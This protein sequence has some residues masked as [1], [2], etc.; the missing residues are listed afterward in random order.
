MLDGDSLQPGDVILSSQKANFSFLIRTFTWSGYSHAAIVLENGLYAEAVGL[1]VR[2]RSIRTV[3]KS[4]LKVLRLKPIESNAARKKAADAAQAI[5]KYLHSCYWTAGALLTIFKN[6]DV[7]NRG[8]LFCSHLVAQV[9]RDANVEILDN[10]SPGKTTPARLE[11]SKV[12]QDVSNSAVFRP[13]YYPGYLKSNEFETLSDH[14]TVTIQGI[15]AEVVPWFSQRNLDIPPT[16]I[17][18][19]QFLADTKNRVLQ[20]QLD[21]VMSGAISR[22]GY[23]KINHCV[24]DEIILP[25]EVMLD[26]IGNFKMK[27]GHAAMEY[28][29][30]EESLE[31]LHTQKITYD[32]NASFYDE[33][34]KQTGLVTFEHLALNATIQSGLCKRITDLTVLILNKLYISYLTGVGDK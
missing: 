5:E 26:Q 9:Y 34:H 27:P 6:T 29:L 11:R 17:H 25:M 20:Q 16:W 32:D 4:K 23:Y 13:A 7:K 2:K 12:F 15:Y 24:R 14:E 28:Y 18:M 30:M 22:S 33:L 8:R 1:G 21:S 31:S 10:I 3:L 19:L